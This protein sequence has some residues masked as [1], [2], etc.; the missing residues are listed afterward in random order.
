MLITI[1]KIEYLENVLKN[2]NHN[3]ITIPC[4]SINDEDV[5]AQLWAGNLN[6]PVLN[7]GYKLAEILKKKSDSKYLDIEAEEDIQNLIINNVSEKS[8]L[9][10]NIG[11]LFENTLNL[12][13]ENL[14][15]KLSK[16]INILLIWSGEIDR[17]KNK[18]F[19]FKKDSSYFIEL[20]S[21]SGY[22]WEE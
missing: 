5:L 8:L 14:F 20:N 9:I 13:L 2:I 17:E 15:Y 19:F 1:D 18:L 22:I 11:I 7:I 4:K 10:Y 21:L 16:M 12:D 3:I 6:I